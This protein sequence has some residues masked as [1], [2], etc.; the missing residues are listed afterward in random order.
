MFI[1]VVHEVLDVP[2]WNKLVTEF[3]EQ[4]GPPPGL[5]LHTSVTAQDGSKLFCLWEADSV[6]A[7]SALLD[8]LTQGVLRNTYYAIDAS[9][10]GTNLPQTALAR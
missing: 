7:V 2:A 8:P 6:D 3:Q 4:G 9:K 10:P 5:T 1:Q